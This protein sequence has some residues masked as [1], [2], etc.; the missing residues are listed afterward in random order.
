M[1]HDN[2]RENDLA[3]FLANFG[4]WWSK[5]W[6]HVL[7]AVLLI[8]CVVLGVRLISDWRTSKREYAWLDL[9][10]TTN[11][12]SY[13]LVAQEYDN[14]TV[15]ALAYLRGGDLYHHQAMHPPAEGDDQALTPQQ[16]LEQA[17]QLY[18]QA[19]E[20]T[21]EPV[22]RAN[23]LL[24]LAAV[25]ETQ[26]RWDQARQYYAQ[27]Q[28]VAGDQL[29]SIAAEAQR[30]QELLDALK[31]P[32]AF[33]PE[34]AVTAPSTQSTADEQAQEAPATQPGTDAAQAPAPAAEGAAPEA[35]TGD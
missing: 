18:Q 29:P 14:P 17:S 35:A 23:A 5:H 10:G 24:G 16:R 33:A 8:A 32:V 20:A 34:P 2:L 21:K 28:Q 11:P 22:Y 26:Q 30:R 27:A 12:E 1:E 15:R 9:A 3:E 4:E 25:A 7:L 13:P 6:Q 19:L 31:Q